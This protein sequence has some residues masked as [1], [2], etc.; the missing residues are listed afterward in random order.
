MYQ[1]QKDA[2]PVYIDVTHRNDEFTRFFGVITD[3]SEDHPT[4]AVI[5][6]FALSMQISK[7]AMCNSSGGIISDGLVALGGEIDDKPDY[8]GF[9]GQKA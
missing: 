3:M 6:K 9:G 8:I 2:V 5:P 7:I 1:Y 4:G